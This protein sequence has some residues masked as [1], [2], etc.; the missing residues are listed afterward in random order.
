ML[1]LAF[2][3][4]SVK[5]SWKVLG[6]LQAI[7]FYLGLL[8]IYK[9]VAQHILQSIWNIAASPLHLYEEGGEVA[10]QRQEK[11]LPGTDELIHLSGVQH[12][13]EVRLW[14]M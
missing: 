10:S 11:S 5:M 14:A 13:T 8:W 12:S 4:Y 2:Y 3:L 1:L 7:Y 6:Q 9:L